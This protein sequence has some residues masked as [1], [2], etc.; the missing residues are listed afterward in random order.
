ML[1]WDTLQYLDTFDIVLLS[2]TRCLGL[3]A[4]FLPRHSVALVPATADGRAGEG[5][6]VA[7]RRQLHVRVQDWASDDTSLWVKLSFAGRPVPLFVAACY[8][9]TAGSPLLRHTSILDRLAALEDRLASA[10]PAGHVLLAGDFNARVGTLP[11]C[12]GPRGATD[13]VVNARGERLLQLAQRHDLMLCTGRAVGDEAG[14]PTFGARANTRPSRLDHVLLSRAAYSSVCSSVVNV[15]RRDSDH[16]PIQTVLRLSAVLAQPSPCQGAPLAVL[17]WRPASRAD[18]VF[19]LADVGRAPLADCMR[20]AA[21][22]D[23]DGAFQALDGAIRHAS[24]AAGMVSR[25]SR[26]SQPEGRVDQPFFDRQC[27]DSKRAVRAVARHGGDRQEFRRLERQYHSLVRAKRRAHRQ[28]E[29]QQLLADQRGDPRRFWKRLRTAARPL[30]PQLQ[31]VQHWDEYLH[32]VAGLEAAGEPTLPHEAY[33]QRDVRLAASMNGAITLREVSDGLKR[34]NNGRSTGVSGLP[35]EFLRYAQAPAAPDIPPPPHLLAAALQAVLHSAFQAGRVPAA[36]NVGLVTPVYKRGDPCDTS[37]YRPIAVTEPIMRLYAVILNA[38]LTAFTEQHGLR[39]AAQNGFRPGL[40]TLHPLFALQHFIDSSRGAGHPLCACFLDLMQA[41]DRIKRPVL[42]GVLGRLGVHGR[43]LAAIQSL[44]ADSSLAVKVAGRVG[45]RLPSR[46]GVKQGCPL[47]PTL[48]GLVLDGMHRY[49]LHHCPTLGVPLRDDLRVTDLEYADDVALLDT[50]PAGLQTLIDTASRF[51]DEVGLRVSPAK[52][53]VMAFGCGPASLPQLTC[54]GQPLRC[55]QSG[56][57]LGVMLDATHGVTST[58]AFLHQKMCAAWALLRRQYAGLRSATS[59]AL[60][61]QLY[62]ACVPPV[63]SYACELW[64]LR[65]MPAALKAARAGLGKSHTAVLRAIVGLR[66]TTP[67]AVV[68][69]ETDSA[70]LHH[71]W[72]I[73]QVRFWNAL[74]GQPAGSLH[75]EVALADCRDAVLRN[76]RNWAHS[77]MRGLHALGYA[78]IIRCDDMDAVPLDSIR[79]LLRRQ[80]ALP[81]Q[82]LHDSPRFCPSLGAQFCTYARWFHRPPWAAAST[83]TTPSRLPLPAAVVRTFVRFRAGCHDL[84]NVAGRRTMTPRFLR[85]CPMC[86]AAL[87]DEMHLVFECPALDHLRTQYARLYSF[88]GQTMLQFMWQPDMVSVACFIRD[89]LRLLLSHEES[90]RSDG[91]DDSSNQP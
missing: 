79:D 14:V 20:L 67:S 15:L 76:V 34:L 48:F 4:G 87:G 89:A 47:S 83:Y 58:C 41:Y 52:T 68:F 45:D 39:S 61:L 9:P 5:L 24:R 64:G 13:T 81:F 35:S 27:A 10:C 28:R 11:D 26:G 90:S 37:N 16:W 44:Y 77:F 23:V 88:S 51:C 32:R 62:Q 72:W 60:L 12:A 69:S 6:L 40:S 85:H 3:P 91:G 84:P 22:G 63:A 50:T 74:A 36:F 65:S 71:L 59:V 70:S 46:M 53:F 31:A 66:R 55:V 17:R 42:W 21:A 57:Y 18:Y 78:F 86:A 8:L 75:R 73:R 30:P 43:M 80:A 56:K 49:L 2:E 38:R 19:A 54:C 29:L 33:P 1:L 7:V 25:A 82:G